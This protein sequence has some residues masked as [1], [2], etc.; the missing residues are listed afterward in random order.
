MNEQPAPRLAPTPTEAAAA[1]Q[2]DDLVIEMPITAAFIEAV[3]RRVAEIL[4]EDGSRASGE[5]LTVREAAGRLGVHENT[6]RG[7]IKE[8]RLDAGKVGRRG[9]WRI[10]ASALD[11]L[12]SVSSAPPVVRKGRAARRRRTPG[13]SLPSFAARASAQNR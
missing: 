13:G 12:I 1:M 7:A 5:Y 4:A 10:E 3:A 9:A 6:I 8:G 11:R 2:S